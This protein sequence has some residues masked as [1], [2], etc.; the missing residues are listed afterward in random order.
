MNRSIYGVYP[1][2]LYMKLFVGACLMI[3][4]FLTEDFALGIIWL[5]HLPY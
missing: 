4:K 3:F 1:P 2:S 5:A